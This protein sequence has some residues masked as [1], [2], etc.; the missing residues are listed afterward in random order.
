MAATRKAEKEAEQLRISQI[1][2]W[3]KRI[4]GVMEMPSGLTAAVRNPGGLNVFLGDGNIPNSLLTII[5]T[6]LDQGRVPDASEFLGEQ[7]Q[8]DPELLKGMDVMLNNVVVKVMVKPRV[9]PVPDN[10]DDRLDTELYADEIPQDD[11]MFLLQW[12]SGGTRD[13]EE[14]RKKQQQ[15][16]DAV[17]QSTSSV[18]AAQLAAGIDPRES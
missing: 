12:V 11:K 9:L 7:G 2:D 18:R 6:A 8:F 1:G 13:L 10:E 15:G 5:R 14:F 3:K 16:M 4:G 17:A